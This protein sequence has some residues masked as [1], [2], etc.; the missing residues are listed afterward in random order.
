[1]VRLLLDAAGGQE[2]RVLP[3][4]G[5]A[6]HGSLGAALAAA[7]P[8]WASPRP[9]DWPRGGEWGS[10]R[11]LLTAGMRCAALYDLKLLS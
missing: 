7:E 5:A 8:D 2:V 3:C 10:V 4:A 6:L 11:V 1:M 9:P